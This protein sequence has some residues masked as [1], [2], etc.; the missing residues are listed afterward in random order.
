MQ[1]IP[2]RTLG[3]V[4]TDEKASTVPLLHFT[5]Q[6]Y[7]RERPTIFVARLWPKSTHLFKLPVSAGPA[8]IPDEVP[9]APP[10]LEYATCFW[11]TYGGSEVTEL[12]IPLTLRLLYVY[13]DHVSAAIF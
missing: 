6:K 3:L 12:V 9:A 7:Q 10:F 8:A 1:T 11:R 13:E 2:G 4:A 5:L